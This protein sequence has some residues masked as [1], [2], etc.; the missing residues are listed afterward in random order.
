MDEKTRKYNK[1]IDHL[2][3]LHLMCGLL[4][5]LGSNV[6]FY[7]NRMKNSQP[8][9]A[10]HES[11]LIMLGYIFEALRGAYQLRG[12]PA[13]AWVAIHICSRGDLEHPAWVREYLKTVSDNLFTDY[14]SFSNKKLPQ[15]FRFNAPGQTNWF[16]RFNE[17][18]KHYQFFEKILAKQL[19]SGDSLATITENVIKSFRKTRK[20]KSQITSI[21]LNNYANTIFEDMELD[22]DEEEKLTRIQRDWFYGRNGKPGINDIDLRFDESLKARKF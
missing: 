18:L 21:K 7:M 8:G 3:N 2:A 14:L 9:E 4:G 11:A 12:N 20:K 5:K 19:S 13:F 6:D 16:K 15:I 22:T 10:E 17:D 1:K